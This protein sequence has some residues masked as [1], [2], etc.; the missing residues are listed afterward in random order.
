MIFSARQLQEKC[1]EQ[2]KP[3]FMT[4][5]DLSKAFDSV[6]RG[7]LWEILSRYGCPPKFINI[8][9][10]F[11]DN[12]TA[13]VRANGLRSDAFSVETGVK[14]G[15][16][17]A[18]TLFALFLCAMLE[19]AQC[20]LKPSV[21][22]LYR[23]DGG[24]FNLRRLQAKS[25]TH[26]TAVV[27]FQFA[28]DSAVCAHSEAEMQ[29]IIDV[30]TEAYE[31]L[32]L[33]L[34]IKKT[35]VLFQPAPGAPEMADPVIRVHD[36]PLECV[37]SFPYLGS[38]LASNT[39]IDSEL[40]HRISAANCRFGKHRKRICDS[41]DLSKETKLFAY[42]AFVLPVLLYSA[43]TWTFYRRHITQLERFQ[44]RC[45]RSPHH[46]THP[47]VREAHQHQRSGEC[48]PTVNRNYDTQVSTAVGGACGADAR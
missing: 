8:I 16:V 46:L 47:L 26:Q 42:Q 25:R 29:H 48:T 14:Q 38:H 4:F 33:Q 17:L 10:L 37:T 31:R 6:D 9:R 36:D 2:Q 12:M 44:Q 35:K 41:C 19:V 18:P 34:N 39:Y 22:I 21:S 43:E 5:F 32:G 24:I 45:L 1:I 40:Q 7:C 28:D 20:R 23:T 30:F 27:E 3:L 15:C 13:T 11:H